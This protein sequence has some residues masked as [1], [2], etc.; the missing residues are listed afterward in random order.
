METGASLLPD[1]LAIL[2]L[3]FHLWQ[4]SSPQGKREGKT[5]PE[6]S[7]QQP[8]SNTWQYQVDHRKKEKTKSKQMQRRKINKEQ[9]M[10]VNV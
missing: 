6:A 4:A 7:R 8:E 1:K 3:I 10:T 9:E 5:Y 2:I